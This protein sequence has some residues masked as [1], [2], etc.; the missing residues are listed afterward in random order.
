LLNVLALASQAPRNL[1]RFTHVLDEFVAAA[2]ALKGD[3]LAHAPVWVV[4][5]GASMD[6]MMTARSGCLGGG[7]RLGLM[8]L[9]SRYWVTTA[10]KAGLDT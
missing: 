5:Q 3:Y 9:A 1:L 6:K 2:P 7:R 10:V 4:K 8:P